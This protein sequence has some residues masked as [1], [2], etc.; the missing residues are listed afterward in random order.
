[1]KKIAALVTGATYL[2]TAV[3][4]FAQGAPITSITVT[5]PPFGFG[6]IGQFITNALFLAFV[7]GIIVVLVMLV[8]GAVQWITSGGDKEAVGAARG[9]ITHAI[10]GLVILAVSY[11]LFHLASQFTGFTQIGTGGFSLPIPGPGTGSGVPPAGPG[12]CPP[13]HPNFNAVQNLC[14]P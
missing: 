6:D 4:I 7:I 5:K 2:I 13:T 10:I 9:R 14:F 12:L 3:S 8:W 1:M 11:A